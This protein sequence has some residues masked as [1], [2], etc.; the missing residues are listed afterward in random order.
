MSSPVSE[1][2]LRRPVERFV[3]H[4]E[5]LAFS[6][7]HVRVLPTDTRFVVFDLD[8]TIHLGRNIGELLGWE[9]CAYQ[10]YGP[11]TL[12]RMEERR[13]ASRFSTSPSLACWRATSTA[14]HDAC[15]R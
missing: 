1:A 9:L 3:D 11:D 4:G 2:C 7:L 14:A 12:A 8:R 15:A 10:T 13:G 6:E 5:P